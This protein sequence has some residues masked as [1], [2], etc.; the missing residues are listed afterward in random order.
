MQRLR[1]SINQLM[2]ALIVGVATIGVTYI[3]DMSKTI[4]TMSISVQELNVKIGQL[5][6]VISDHET[7]IREVERRR[8]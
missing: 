4:Q 6:L 2:L 1:D 7:R 8:R 3:G 5:A